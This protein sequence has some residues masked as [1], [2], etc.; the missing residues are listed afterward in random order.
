MCAIHMGSNNGLAED[1][2]KTHLNFSSASVWLKEPGI[3][4]R[5]LL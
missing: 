5:K 4:N 1:R 3:Y 2:H